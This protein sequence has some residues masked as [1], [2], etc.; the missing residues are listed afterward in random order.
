MFLDRS[1]LQ[2][3][4]T[5]EKETEVK[6]VP[7]H[8]MGEWEY[9]NASQ[10]RYVSCSVKCRQILNRRK[11]RGRRAHSDHLDRVRERAQWGCDLVKKG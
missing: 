11:R 10:M 6:G 4:E 9:K 8:K 1:R 3:T 7:V 2:V 5:V